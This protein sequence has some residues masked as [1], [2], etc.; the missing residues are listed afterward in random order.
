MYNVHTNNLGL[1]EKSHFSSGSWFLCD[2]KIKMP[3]Q[4]KWMNPYYNI[5]VMCEWKLPLYAYSRVVVM[6]R[7]SFSI[8]R[9]Q[10]STSPNSLSALLKLSISE[11]HCEVCL[12][13]TIALWCNCFASASN[14]FWFRYACAT[15]NK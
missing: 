12:E 10:F 8:V 3:N 11:S 1:A 9:V 4:L 5:Y 2:C 7:M 13:K 6:L 15:L 14:F